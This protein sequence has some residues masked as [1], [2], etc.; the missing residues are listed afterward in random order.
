MNYLT[1]IA[2]NAK[3]SKSELIRKLLLDKKIRV[4]YKVVMDNSEIRE[5]IG[6]YGKIGSNLNQ[7]AKYYNT[8]GERSLAIDDEIKQCISELFEL[9]KKVLKVLGGYYGNH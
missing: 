8:G 2:D 4:T 1:Q 7:I 6:E 3:L 5:L 9:R